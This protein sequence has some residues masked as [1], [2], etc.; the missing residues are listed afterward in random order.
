[1][2]SRLVRINRESCRQ[3]VG[4]G[5]ADPE[6]GV[7]IKEW[8]KELVVTDATFFVSQLGR[9]A[10]V[11]ANAM[12]LHAWIEGYWIDGE[13]PD[14]PSNQLIAIR[15]NPQH[16][17]TFVTADDNQPIWTAKRVLF[18]PHGAFIVPGVR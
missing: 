17:T 14:L 5:I 18:H 6:A 7:Y 1:M 13:A 10:A 12:T 4:W 15:Y 2:S 9:R 16:H 11:K 8:V 3:G